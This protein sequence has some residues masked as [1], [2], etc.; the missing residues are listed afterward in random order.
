M[1]QS[2]L[3]TLEKPEGKALRNASTRRGRNFQSK[4]KYGHHSDQ[5]ETPKGFFQERRANEMFFLFHNS[6]QIHVQNPNL[7]FLLVSHLP[8]VLLHHHHLWQDSSRLRLREEAQQSL[9]P[10]C[11]HAAK[12]RNHDSDCAKIVMLL[13]LLPIAII[14]NNSPTANLEVKKEIV[15]AVVSNTFFMTPVVSNSSISSLLPIRK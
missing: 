13:I 6:S 14:L 5:K 7:P 9:L 11:W 1:T 2:S 8:L 10:L 4:P 15:T 3:L 12:L